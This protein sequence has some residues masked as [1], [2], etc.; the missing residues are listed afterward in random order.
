MARRLA[1]SR[2]PLAPP[3]TPGAQAGWLYGLAGLIP[4]FAAAAAIWAG[5][6][7]LGRWAAVAALALL[8][9]AATIISFLG[10][11]RW[12][13]ELQRPGGPDPRL[14]FLSVTP[15]LAAWALLFAR[16]PGATPLAWRF[17]GLLAVLVVVGVADVLS[18]DLPEWYR[19]LRIPLTVGAGVALLAALAWTLRHP[20]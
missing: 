8:S 5:P 13:F 11:V 4:F 17:G 10:G 2:R 20:A 3:V 12:G 19:T 14:L 1:S 18:R 7:R 15:Q 16:M 9:Y 6:E